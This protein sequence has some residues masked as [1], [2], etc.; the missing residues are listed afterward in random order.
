MA[1]DAVVVGLHVDPLAVVRVVEPV[2]QR[3]AETGHQAVD[4][5]ACAWLILI[6]LLRQRTAECGD[7]SAHHVHGMRGGRQRL[8]RLLQRCGQAAQRA[9]LRLVGSEFG[10]SWQRAVHQE[11]GDLLKLAGFGDV[12]D[13]VTAVVQVIAGASDRAQRRVAGGD[14]GQADASLCTV[15]KGGGVAHGWLLQR[16]GKTWMV[17]TRPAVMAAV[18]FRISLA[19]RQQACRRAGRRS[20]CAALPP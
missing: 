17:G 5:V 19:C 4:D 11:V 2:E 14:A 10:A 15:G 20:T 1:A 7:G 18:T 16:E 6:L 9:Q 8:E 13:V 3:G 12:E